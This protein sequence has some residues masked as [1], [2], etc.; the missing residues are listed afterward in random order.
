MGTCMWV[1]AY[2]YMHGCIH[3]YVHTCIRA[4]VH[5][6]I[7]T[8]VPDESERLSAVMDEAKAAA[9]AEHVSDQ[10]LSL[11]ADEGASKVFGLG[12]GPAAV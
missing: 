7:L 5:T 8:Q 10:A 9:A 2:G 1:H 12:L 3:S 4:H 6:Y 11:D